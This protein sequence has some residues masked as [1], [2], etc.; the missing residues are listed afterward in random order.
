MLRAWCG[1]NCLIIVVQLFYLQALCNMLKRDVSVNFK[2]K[3]NPT[4]TVLTCNLLY[5]SYAEEEHWPQQFIEVS[6]GLEDLG[7]VLNVMSID[8]HPICL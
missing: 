3:G 6:P 2:A 5:A 8:N 4:V 1:S 7:V